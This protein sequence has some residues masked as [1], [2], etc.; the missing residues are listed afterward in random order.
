MSDETAKKPEALNVR[1]ISMGLG[2]VLGLLVGIE[3]F[4]DNVA[5]GI[6]V[7]VV[8]GSG[9]GYMVGAIIETLRRK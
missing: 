1:A 5:M 7:G 3:L 8:A 2:F 6:M 4:D 9:V